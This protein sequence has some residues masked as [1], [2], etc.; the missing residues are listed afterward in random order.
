MLENITLSNKLKSKLNL[1]I[2]FLK[3]S[4]LQSMFLL[5]VLVF[6]KSIKFQQLFFPASPYFNLSSGLSSNWI[7]EFCQ[8]IILSANKPDRFF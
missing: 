8:V 4:A 6:Q 7:K 2:N 5:L 3:L 1:L